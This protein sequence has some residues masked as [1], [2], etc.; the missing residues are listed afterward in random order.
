MC[1]CVRVCVRIIIYLYLQIQF[2]TY[3][4]HTNIL[5]HRFIIEQRIMR[6][7][8]TFYQITIVIW[9]AC[10]GAGCPVWGGLYPQGVYGG[11]MPQPQHQPQRNGWNVPYLAA[12]PPTGGT[13]APRGGTG[14]F[15]PI[16]A[17]VR[18]IGRASPR[19]TTLCADYASF[20]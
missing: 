16:V 14:D 13:V 7:I 10:W 19:P 17:P 1:A 6:M 4:T 18:G 20:S 5:N 3:Y 11:G 2:T 15:S 9:R 8:I 12:C